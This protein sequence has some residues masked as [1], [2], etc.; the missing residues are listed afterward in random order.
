MAEKQKRTFSAR[1][2]SQGYIVL[3]TPLRRLIFFGGLIGIVLLSLL[4]AL[5]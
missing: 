1:N 3:K 5:T 4:L 2:A